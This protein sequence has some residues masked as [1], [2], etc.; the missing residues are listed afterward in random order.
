MHVASGSWLHLLSTA[1]SP[2]NT[3]QAH[4]VTRCSSRSFALC[5]LAADDSM[6]KASPLSLQQGPIHYG[7]GCTIWKQVGWSP[8]G[9]G[10]AA[11]STAKAAEG[12]AAAAA[13]M[14]PDAGRWAC[15]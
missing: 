3:G 7:P 12:M 2:S 13:F 8:A 4:K 11:S 14:L 6:A 1:I 9:H 10:C 15:P 5:G